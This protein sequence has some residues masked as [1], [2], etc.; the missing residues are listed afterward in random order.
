M[1]LSLMW[2][3]VA[4]GMVTLVTAAMKVQNTSQCKGYSINITGSDDGKLFTSKENIEK[5]LKAATKGNVKGQ[6]MTEF[7]LPQIEDLL[8]Q[9]AWV[10]NAELYFDNTNMLRV[11]VIERKPLARVFTNVG[12]SFYIDESGRRIPLSDKISLDV[13]VFT[14][15]PTKKILNAGD[16]ALMQNVIATASFIN[17]DKFWSSQVSQINISH[18]GVKGWQMEMVPV[19]GNHRVQLGDG[20]DIAT[21]FH[22]L[23]LFYDQVLKRKGF[24]K[25]QTIDVQYDGQVLGM[26]GNYTKIDSLQLRKNIETLLEQSRDANELI[27]ETP[28][29][30]LSNYIM[31]TVNAVPIYQEPGPQI[32]DT[33]SLMPAAIEKPA[34]KPA[35]AE[36][37]KPKLVQ[38]ESKLLE[39]KKTEAK[40][41]DMKKVEKKTEEKRSSIKKT[42]SKPVAKA[43]P[44]KEVK[45]ETTPVVKK[46]VKPAVKKETVEKDVKPNAKTSTPAKAA[47]AKN[48]AT[49]TKTPEKKSVAK[50]ATKK[51]AAKHVA[52]PATK[53]DAK[54]PT[55]IKPA[56]TNKKTTSSKTTTKKT[57]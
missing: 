37:K 15:F 55:A 57:N 9:S 54:K 51:P 49:R 3:C 8:E 41:T 48:T 40:K 28:N 17:E 32:E 2:L 56:A 38:E 18:Q 44:E 50:T 13:P 5:L 46:K 6:R 11:N 4:A 47:P 25:Y 53:T 35:Q 33:V 30:G 23:Y 31:D 34:I 22:R 27:S 39:K 12:E 7:N 26:K 24:D 16:S 29:I 52:K 20:S 21:K 1:F 10:Y 19:V 43:D 36:E 14:G 45:K 42:E